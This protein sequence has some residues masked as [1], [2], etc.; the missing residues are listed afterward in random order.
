MPR[1]DLIQV[2]RGNT[3]QW[4]AANPVLASGEPGFDV[5]T[6]EFK[7]GDGATAWDSLNGVGTSGTANNTRSLNFNADNNGTV[8]STGVK[9]YLNVPFDCTI[10]SWTIVANETGSIVIDVWKDSYANF[11]PTVADTITGSEK[12]T[13]SSAQTG[14][15]NSLT[16]WTTSLSAGDVLAFVIDS[17][18]DI[19][20]VSLSIKANV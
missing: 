13:I 18:T 4:T 3:T 17:V 2:R 16:T 20:N 14:Q 8:L 6:N 12:P 15:D 5:T 7:V 1:E 19:T 9:G 10:D 11:P